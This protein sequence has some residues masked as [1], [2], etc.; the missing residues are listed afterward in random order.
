M[1]F[2]IFLILTIVSLL[3]QAYQINKQI[4]TITAIL[5]PNEDDA[6]VQ[7]ALLAAAK[8]RKIV[9]IIYFWIALLLIIPIVLVA[10]GRI[11]E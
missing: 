10:S 6:D 2:C 9:S 11:L 5:Y 3:D 7:A 1:G 8:K 4:H